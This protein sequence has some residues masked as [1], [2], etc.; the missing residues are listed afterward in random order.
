MADFR[1]LLWDPAGPVKRRFSDTDTFELDTD[2]T[3]NIF[4]LKISASSVFTLSNAG[5][6]VQAPSGATTNFQHFDGTR[7][8][9]TGGNINTDSG[10]GEMIRIGVDN[11]SG[12][13]NT[14]W[15][16]AYTSEVLPSAGASTW[17]D[18]LALSQTMDLDGDA[19][20][21]WTQTD[22]TGYGFIL[23]KTVS[24]AAN[25]LMKIETTNTSAFPTGT[26]LL[27][28]H[29]SAFNN[30]GVALS[31]KGYLELAAPNPITTNKIT[32]SAPL[33]ISTSAFQHHINIKT[34]GND[35]D[36][37]LETS[38][39]ATS[40][41]IFITSYGVLYMK[42]TGTSAD[43]TLE[44]NSGLHILAPNEGADFTCAG[45][46][47]LVSGIDVTFD[48]RGTT[49]PIAFNT[50][51][52]KDLTT[53]K[54]SIVGAI[55][56][57]NAGLG[58]TTLDYAYNAD[59]GAAA[60]AVDAGNVTW[61][62]T[63]PYF[64]AISKPLSAS[65]GGDSIAARSY[66]SS[67][68]NLVSGDVLTAYTARATGNGA[69]DAGDAEVIAFS[70]LGDNTTAGLSYG[71][72]ANDK[73]GYGLYSLATSAVVLTGFTS[74]TAGFVVD[75]TSG[76]TSG[77]VYGY[78]SDL[79]AVAGDTGTYYGYLALIGGTT[80]NLTTSYGFSAD[81]DWDYG[82][83]IES[84][85][86]VES[87]V[88]AAASGNAVISTVKTAA[89]KTAGTN[90]AVKAVI[91]KNVS[92]VAGIWRGFEAAGDTTGAAEATHGYYADAA[93]D[94][95]FY[96]LTKNYVKDALSGTESITVWDSIA[97]ASAART[98]GDAINY[99]AQISPHASDTSGANYFGF[100]AL[101]SATGSGTK[102][103]FYSD[104]NWDYGLYSLA[105]AT[106]VLSSVTNP[107]ALTLSITSGGIVSGFA[108]S[109]VNL[110]F[111]QDATDT[112]SVYGIDI[113][114][115]VDA[116][117]T[118]STRAVNIDADWDHGLYSAS[119]LYTSTGLN[120]NGGKTY[121]A[122]VVGSTASQT[123]FTSYG[124]IVEHIDGGTGAGFFEGIQLE[125]DSTS[126]AATIGLTIDNEW[127]VGFASSSRGVVT[128]TTTTNNVL[129][130]TG[131]PASSPAGS[132]IVVKSS[133][134]SPNL[135]SGDGISL[136]QASPTGHAL[137]DVASTYAGF[138]AEGTAT[139]SAVK[140]GFIADAEWDY[141]LL[142]FA[143]V[144]IG[145][146]L[147]D[148]EDGLAVNS[149][150][151]GLG[152]G[153]AI[154]GIRSD[155]TGAGG[156]NA[157][158][159]LYGFYAE[160]TATGPANKYGVV[161]DSEWDV[162]LL[163]FAKVIIG[164]TLSD[165][166]NVLT[167][168]TSS[169]TLT[170]G[171]IL[172]GVK[173]SIT[174]H[175]SDAS[176]S[177][178]YGF[179]AEG[180]TTGSAVKIAYYADANWTGGVWI[181]DAPSYFE[182]VPVN[183][184]GSLE[185]WTIESVA[186][187]ADAGLAS[188]DEVA[189]FKATL[190]D[191]ADDLGAFYYGL[192]LT[193]TDVGPATKWGIHIDTTW[194]ADQWAM[195]IRSGLWYLEED[196]G[197]VTANTDYVD[198]NLS[199]LLNSSNEGRCINLDITPDSSQADSSRW[200]GV[201]ANMANTNA[202]DTIGSIAFQAN[203][204]WHYGLYANDDLSVQ[205]T[206]EGKIHLESTSSSAVS[207]G[208]YLGYSFYHTRNASDTAGGILWAY[209]ADSNNVT[210]LLGIGGFWAG[211]GINTGFYSQAVNNVFTRADDLSTSALPVV[212][213]E[214]LDNDSSG[215]PVPALKLHKD[216]VGAAGTV[217]EIDHA[218]NGSDIQDTRFAITFT[219]AQRNRRHVPLETYQPYMSSNTTEDFYLQSSSTGST[220]HRWRTYSTGYYNKVIHAPLLLPH[221]STLQNVYFT[222]YQAAGNSATEAE[223]PRVEIYSQLYTQSQANTILDFSWS[224][225]S[226]TSGTITISV[227]G[228]AEVVDNTDTYYFARFVTGDN[229]HST[230]YAMGCRYDY[231]IT[232]FGAA[233]GL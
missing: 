226:A 216:Y 137:D 202:N 107:E 173:S 23:K 178:I 66:I 49:T 169:G 111:I 212:L 154:T 125:G 99:R 181:T 198:V 61:T 114:L 28:V 182:N 20:L 45:T 161:V 162:G 209:K 50:V 127:D 167:V 82:L 129:G 85:G 3:N 35:S 90:V 227:T 159:S 203:A 195:R 11:G 153:E 183:G 152:S 228:L 31:L 230:I 143:K 232:D 32:S 96:S 222:F 130:V 76:G 141:G 98:A 54:Q 57:V 73:C 18:L 188:N 62:L 233:P 225:Y 194:P 56:E 70:A 68:A 221:G 150:S 12:G 122:K 1:P 29:R 51:A 65:P 160:G 165:T 151:G 86:Y 175:A 48:A 71:F 134:T 37:T 206:A 168:N 145:D 93:W 106:V 223:R 201:R 6:L 25:A 109:I 132:L 55:N 170:A 205:Q 75:T 180:D 15:V 89:L 218:Y 101:G 142:S 207:S 138:Y 95:G 8:A 211:P 113:G 9:G 163:S 200:I 2:G 189:A 135:A 24:T 184:G 108:Q 112:G 171:E 103:G 133:F 117:A 176:N 172:S 214:N 52:D 139:G 164:D 231:D 210:G 34:T 81:N 39:Q 128:S 179:F 208:T 192:Y 186:D 157:L 126:T 118:S 220:I 41:D 105:P 110:D 36:I 4:D 224:S 7:A 148:T 69:G 97:E 78:R 136:F 16:P 146:T 147:A 59:A 131:I 187:A 104:T 156:D 191:D 10:S 33:E 149:T 193:T 185:A 204:N 155:V 14:R 229:S 87:T 190:Q 166:D 26:A 219:S 100:Y 213:I 217:L 115:T 84:P 60:I 120:A 88:A 22:V 77:S 79:T 27:E 44:S 58:G 196:F 43:V 67:S 140:Y 19:P 123:S 42:N 215:G 158:S 199:G 92:D 116:L 121:V 197:T 124:L 40:S 72:H 38:A 13:F 83:F 102:Y 17:D 94:Y 91:V 47:E 46:I 53:T 119:P 30:Q 63:E 21:T 64:I 177:G 80:S 5:V 174:G 144:S 74:T